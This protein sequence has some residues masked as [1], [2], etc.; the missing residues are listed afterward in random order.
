[1]NL[2]PALNLNID[3]AGGLGL[4]HINASGPFE[5]KMNFSR[6]ASARLNY[7][8]RG[9]ERISIPSACLLRSDA[10]RWIHLVGICIERKASSSVPTG[11]K[12]GA[13]SGV[14][15]LTYVARSTGSR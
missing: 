11:R 3:S 10:S 2:N 13:A 12:G 14:S 6:S 5:L 4:I 1:L 7:C 8:S 9:F 15:G